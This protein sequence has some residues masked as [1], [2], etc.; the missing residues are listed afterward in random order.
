MQGD[1]V[2][3]GF[4]RDVDVRGARIIELQSS[5]ILS[6]THTEFNLTVRDIAKTL[7][8]L[9]WC[10]ALELVVESTSVS[11]YIARSTCGSLRHML[12]SVVGID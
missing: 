12:Q 5:V 9:T 6:P 10:N 2:G 3:C 7:E 4:L 1:R 8:S 11:G